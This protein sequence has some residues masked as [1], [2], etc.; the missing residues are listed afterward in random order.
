MCDDVDQRD[1]LRAC[2][3]RRRA[4]A[5]AALGTHVDQPVG[6]LDDVEVVLDHQHAVALVDQRLQHAEQLVDVLEVQAGRR[7]VE[8]VDRL[9]GRA[10]LQLGGELDPLG[11]T[12]GQRRRRLAEPDVA[13]PDV[14]QRVE[15]AGDAAD[16]LEELGRLLDRHLE[17]L[18]DRLALVVHLERLAVVAGALADLARHVDVGQEVHLDLDRAVAGA[19][20]AAPALDVEREPALLVTADLGLG[21]L[22]EQLADVVEHAGVG[23][24]VRARGAP[25][26]RLVDADDLVDLLDARAPA[27]AG[28]AAAGRR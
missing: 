16:R 6:G 17:H 28:P 21:R 22:G 20:L 13:E 3:R 9:A 26:R 11:L 4:A 8:H 14:D 2:P 1:L 15:V 5:G 18:G 12:A 23:R 24:R 7:L 19:V 27:G 25:D 10:L